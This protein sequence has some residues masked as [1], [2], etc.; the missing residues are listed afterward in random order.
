MY[1][2]IFEL[3]R[4]AAVKRNL[5]PSTAEAYCRTVRYFMDS[6]KKSSL[7]ELTVEDVENFLLE[8][9]AAG[10][11]PETYNHY[12]SAIKFLYRRLL[13][14]SWDEDDIPRMKNERSLPTVLTKEEIEGILEATRNIKHRAMIAT[15]Y[16]G[17]LRVSEL[18]HLHYD[19]ISRTHHSIHIRS[20]KS[21]VDRYTILADRT[22]DLLTEYWFACGRPRDILFPSSYS[23]SYLDKNTVN[24]FLKKSAKKAGIEKH[25]S[26]HSLRHSFASHLLESGCDIKYIQAL[27]GHVDPKSTEVYLH[28]SDKTLLGIRS[29]FDTP[30]AGRG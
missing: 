11:R 3:I 23:G 21:R 8:K 13:K 6:V 5:K 24:Q 4:Q 27:L 30:E 1:E 10:I 25:L 20:S 9:Q 17:G 16:S 19:D 2:D 15:M 18:V 12:H 28:V 26:T 22:L 7:A 29:P 14:V